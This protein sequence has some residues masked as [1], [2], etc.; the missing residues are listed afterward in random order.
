M[1]DEP[2]IKLRFVKTGKGALGVMLTDDS[3]G[4]EPRYLCSLNATGQVQ[5]MDL[6]MTDYPPGASLWFPA[7]S[8]AD[9][10]AW[11]ATGELPPGVGGK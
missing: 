9:W 3:Q 4:S 5:L 7:S 2:T 1:A 10:R 8:L 11:Q 6:M